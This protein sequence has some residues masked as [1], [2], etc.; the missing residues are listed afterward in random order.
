MNDR[1]ETMNIR[2]AMEYLQLGES[3]VRNMVAT[4][5]I[6]AKKI[7]NKLYLEAASVRAILDFSKDERAA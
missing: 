7:R 1:P 6:R 5:E 2:E 4:G 3:T